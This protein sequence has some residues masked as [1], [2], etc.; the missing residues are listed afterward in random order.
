VKQLACLGNVAIA[1]L[2]PWSRRNGGKRSTAPFGKPSRRARLYARRTATD[3]C[4]TGQN[5]PPIHDPPSR[6]RGGRRCASGVA[7]S[8]V[9]ES[10]NRRPVGSGRAEICSRSPGVRRA[11]RDGFP[12]G[13]VDRLAPF[14]RETRREW[15]YRRHYPARQLFHGSCTCGDNRIS[16]GHEGPRH[17][18]CSSWREFDS[19]PLP[20]PETESN[21]SS[22]F[23]RLAVKNWTAKNGFRR[24]SPA[25]AERKAVHALA[26]NAVHHRRVC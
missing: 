24:S 8:R 23:L 14:L 16:S 19:C 5:R 18:R 13:A 20:S 17:C 3:F 25:P 4:T 22:P 11:R 12:K 1:P 10:V 7:T 21:P 2:S 15:R 26:R 9:C 6:A